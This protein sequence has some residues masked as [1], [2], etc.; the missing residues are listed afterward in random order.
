MKNTL[1]ILQC[2]KRKGNIE[3][4][5]GEDFNLQARVPRTR[6]ILTDSIERFTRNGAIEGSSKPITALS[7]YDGHF[8]RASRLR[9]R[10]A[11]EIRNGLFQFLIMSAGYGIVHPF[12]KIKRYEQRMTG[13]TTKYWLN[14]GLPNVLQ[15]FIET[16]GY[17]RTYGIFSKSADYRI[18]LE[19][20]AWHKLRGLEDVGYFYLE[21]MRG[22]SKILK[23]LAMLMLTLLDG[24][25]NENPRFFRGAE[26]IFTKVV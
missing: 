16:G 23:S 20:V 21:G 12:Q 11:E 19:E 24:N 22:A 18:M 14:V 4:Y 3:L 15:E 5:P 13:S 25:F 17:K 6:K 1:V 7:R 26:V 10:V 8:Y 9:S 2:C